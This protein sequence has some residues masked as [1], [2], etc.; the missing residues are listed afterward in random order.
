MYEVL[1]LVLNLLLGGKYLSYFRISL[2]EQKMVM[3]CNFSKVILVCGI[4]GFCG[5]G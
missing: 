2:R 5:V 4:F 3:V 1:I